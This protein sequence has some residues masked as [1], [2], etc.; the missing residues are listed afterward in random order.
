MEYA[1]YFK[2]T[3]K[4]GVI[5]IYVFPRLSRY[6]ANLSLPGAAALAATDPLWRNIKGEMMNDFSLFSLSPLINSPQNLSI[7]SL[8]DVENKLYTAY[9][10]AFLT[11]FQLITGSL[12]AGQNDEH[13]PFIWFPDAANRERHHDYRN[14]WFCC[15]RGFVLHKLEEKEPAFYA[16]LVEF[17]WLP[18]TEAPPDAHSTWEDPPVGQPHRR[19]LSPGLG[20]GVRH[21]GYP[22]KCGGTNHLIM[23]DVLSGK[24][25]FFLPGLITSLCKRAGVPLFDADEVLSM[26]SPVHPLLVRTCST[27][28]SKRRRTGRGSN[29]K[30]AVNL[31]D[32]DPFSGARV[33]EDLEAVRKRMWSAY[34]DFTPVPPSTTLE[35]EMLRCQLRQERRKGLVRDRLMA[36]MWKTVKVIFSY[37]APDREVP[38]LE[39]EDY[40]E[41]PILN[42]AWAGEKPP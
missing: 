25:A 39:P 33:E 14:T 16:R 6:G 23:E 10:V 30:T 34:A 4:I 42:E 29:S 2:K 18:L 38:R 20:G 31:D 11:D 36:R 13:L 9:S 41:F 28:R 7:T 26:D 12:M 1:R 8:S 5:V 24:N 15:E 27:S 35:V 17:E 21:T 22:A 3:D 32:D 19:D 37:V 40:A